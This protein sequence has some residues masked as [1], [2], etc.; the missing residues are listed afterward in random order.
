MALL[1]HYQSD[2]SMSAVKSAFLIFDSAE[3]ITK[4]V[5]VQK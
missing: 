3:V 2:T 5:Y 1:A 4:A